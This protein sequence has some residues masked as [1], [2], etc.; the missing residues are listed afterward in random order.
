[1][2]QVTAKLSL[3]LHKKQGPEW[4]SSARPLD[5]TCDTFIFQATTQESV[6]E[7]EDNPRD[8]PLLSLSATSEAKGKDRLE[9]PQNNKFSEPAPPLFHF[10]STERNSGRGRKACHPGTAASKAAG[11]A[12]CEDTCRLPPVQQDS[13]RR[14]LCAS[15]KETLYVQ[16]SVE[17]QAPSLSLNVL[18][19]P[20]VGRHGSGV[21]AVLPLPAG[22]TDS[23]LS[24]P[25]PRLSVL[26]PGR[27]SPIQALPTNL[28]RC[29]V[30][31]AD[32]RWGNADKLQSDPPHLCL[33]HQTSQTGKLPFQK[34]K[35]LASLLIQFS[36]SI[37]TALF[38]VSFK[39]FQKIYQSFVNI[40]LQR[41]EEKAK[42]SK[43]FCQFFTSAHNLHIPYGK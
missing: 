10:L 34:E 18:R 5:L 30:L 7:S 33:L 35:S 20:R 42:F 19:E 41:E 11:L 24:L 3:I 1:N 31:A 22:A 43:D 6:R 17:L 27:A 25:E 39:L 12:H 29:N 21:D 36:L 28:L 15:N 40:I 26:L 23:V 16:A 38:F 4:K 2:L 9:E 37:N 13:L 8:K 32:P 14:L